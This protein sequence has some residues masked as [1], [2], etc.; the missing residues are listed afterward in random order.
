MLRKNGGTD[1]LEVAKYTSGAGWG[2]TLD[3]STGTVTANVEYTIRGWVRQRAVYAKLDGQ[4]AD[5]TYHS[6]S[7]FGAGKVGTVTTVANT[8]DLLPI[9]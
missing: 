6:T 3:S 2:G 8:T 7:F 5:F 4:N 1:T 9:F